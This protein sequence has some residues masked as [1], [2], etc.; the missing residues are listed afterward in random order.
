MIASSLFH[1]TKKSKTILDI[2]IKKSLRASLNIENVQNFFPN[3]KYISTPMVCFCDIPLKYISVN[4]TK[5]YGEYGFGFNKDWGIKNKVNPILYWSNN[6]EFSKSFNKSSANITDIYKKINLLKS[7]TNK[8]LSEYDDIQ[9][10][11]ASLKSNFENMAGY[12]K[13]FEE[14]KRNNYIDRE[15]R[16]VPEERNKEFHDQNDETYRKELNNVYFSNPD[17]FNLEDINYLIVKEK[18]D[19]KILIK[20]LNKLSIENEE[21]LILTQKIIDIKSINSDM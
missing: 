8:E 7:L 18:K 10:H 9:R 2:L 15:W 13:S 17:Y 4:H 19:I 3:K 14:N 1:F 21:K 12:V 5:R 16:W 6:S 11:L 20:R